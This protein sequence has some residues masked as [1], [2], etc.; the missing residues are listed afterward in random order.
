MHYPRRASMASKLAVALALAVAFPCAAPAKAPAVA[1]TGLVSSADEAEMEGVLVSASKA[2]SN[3]TVT[4]V[5]GADGRYAFPA[6]RLGPG[7]YTIAVR[8]VGYQLDPVRQKESAIEIKP[9]EAGEQKPA[10]RD[11]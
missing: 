8:A 7:Q 2:G 1:L 11:I 3:I 10:T 4:V 6:N 5:T 9:S